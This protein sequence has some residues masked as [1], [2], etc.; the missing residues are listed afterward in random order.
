[1][2]ASWVW[3]LMMAITFAIPAKAGISTVQVPFYSDIMAITYESDVLKYVPSG[4]FTTASPG[5]FRVAMNKGSI[6]VLMGSLLAK[7]QNMELNDWLYFVLVKN[8]VDK[9]MPSQTDHARV[10]MTWYLMARSGYQVKLL[11][12]R[13]RPWLYAAFEDKVYEVAYVEMDEGKFINL[14]G[15]FEP[16]DKRQFV[17]YDSEELFNPSA[18]VF[19]FTMKNLPVMQAP[20][21][22]KKTLSFTYDGKVHNIPVTGDKKMAGVWHTYPK[23]SL[24]TY[25]RVPLSGSAYNSVIPALRKALEG[26][27]TYTSVRMLLSFTRQA[28]AYETDAAG[29]NERELVLTPE[30]TLLAPYS[31]CEDRA[32]LFY[33]LVK[34]LLGLDAVFIDFPTH[35]A[36]AVGMNETY[37]LTFDFKNRKYTFCEP[38]GPQ[39]VLEIGQLSKN[40]SAKTASVL[41]DE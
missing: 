39:D 3:G 27:D 32:V 15:F 22:I 11:H 21:L 29:Y 25:T 31:D 13:Q 6:Q 9:I 33:Y 4:K 26:K 41:K 28:F 16:E 7:K 18:K 40:Y 20:T 2:K 12:D 8:T 24:Y 23:L 17:I 37:G 35:V 34:E 1:M 36:V 38:T 30:Q 14:T 19:D 5:A 10:M